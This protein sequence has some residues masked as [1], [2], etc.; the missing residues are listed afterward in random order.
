MNASVRF[1]SR[2]A[3]DLQRA[4]QRYQQQRAGLGNE[5][6]EDMR[7]LVEALEQCPERAPEYYRGFRCLV[8]RRFPY[9]LFYRVVA[10]QV[11]VFRVLHARQ[12]HRGPLGPTGT[13]NG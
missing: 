4:W 13:P 11:I 3:T 6:L 12:N 2:A 10:G 5:F 1:R 9:K 7:R 8:A